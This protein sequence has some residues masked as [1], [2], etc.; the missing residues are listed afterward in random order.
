M[1]KKLKEVQ[2]KPNIGQ[3]SKKMVESQ[4]KQLGEPTHM[5]LYY[6]NKHPKKKT[7]EKVYEFVEEDAEKLVAGKV[8]KCKRKVKKLVKKVIFVFLLLQIRKSKI[9]RRKIR[10]KTKRNLTR[11][12]LSNTYLDFTK[13]FLKRKNV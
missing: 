12:S 3:N 13:M 9:V 4:N 6:V 2:E 8:I 7:E 10:I 1:N 5:R 11:L